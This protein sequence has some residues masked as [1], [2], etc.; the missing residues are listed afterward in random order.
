MPLI[1]VTMLQGRTID[2]KRKIAARITDTMVEEAGARR[3]AIV[4]TFIEVSKES[5]ASGGELMI[6]KAKTAPFEEIG[7]FPKGR[8]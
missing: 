6:D 1:Q 5:Y 3:E 7:V 2:Q 4:V 8:K